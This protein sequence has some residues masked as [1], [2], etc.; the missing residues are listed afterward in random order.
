VAGLLS[1]G[2]L[3]CHLAKPSTTE[4]HLPVEPPPGWRVGQQQAH[5]NRYA[6]SFVPKQR[7][8]M[9]KMWVTILRKPEVSAQSP[10]GLITTFQPHF[11]CQSHDLN[12]LKKEL[13]DIVFEEKDAVCYGRNYKYT[14]GRIVRGR[15]TVTY[16]AYRAD[17]LEL[18]P[19]RRDFVLKT[20]TSAPLDASGTAPSDKPPAAA[21]SP[22]APAAAAS[23]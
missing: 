11:I 1:A 22:A 14:I 18:P 15:N 3:G 19:G 2:L 4:H 7:T 8:I 9:E 10:N 12:V 23:H 13:N 20:I 17:Q 6:V 21:T 5:P 16:Y